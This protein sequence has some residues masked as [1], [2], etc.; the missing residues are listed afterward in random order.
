ME[1]SKVTLLKVVNGFLLFFLF[2]LIVGCCSKPTKSSGDAND[3]VSI[4]FCPIYTKSQVHSK[5]FCDYFL[6]T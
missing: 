6:G 3:T 4:T 5:C 2:G 1:Q